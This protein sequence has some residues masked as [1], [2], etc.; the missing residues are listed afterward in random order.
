MILYRL[1]KVLIAIL[2]V[3]IEKLKLFWM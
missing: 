3:I 1:K 2:F